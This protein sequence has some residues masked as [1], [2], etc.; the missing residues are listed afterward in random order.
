MGNTRVLIALDKML[1]RLTPPEAAAFYKLSLLPSKVLPELATHWLTEGLDTHSLV[2]LA[3][4]TDPIMSDVGPLFESALRELDLAL[5]AQAPA[6]ITALEVYVRKI[7]TRAINPWEAMDRIED[8]LESSDLFPDVQ[9]VGDGLGLE[10][11][12]GWYRELQDTG[13]GTH[14]HYY[15]DLTEEEAM[16]QFKENLIQEAKRRLGEFKQ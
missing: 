15:P 6:T 16:A 12:H 2:L 5:P 13:D 14:V 11:M 3:G 4:E 1:T 8:D 9:F 10:R 7:A